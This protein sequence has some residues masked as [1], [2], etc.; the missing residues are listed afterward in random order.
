MTSTF[1]GLAT[2]AAGA[3]RS[4]VP[5]TSRPDDA[6]VQ[7]YLQMPGGQFAEA[8]GPWPATASGVDGTFSLD[9]WMADEVRPASLAWRIY[10]GSA[11]YRGPLQPGSGPYDLG[12]LLASRVWESL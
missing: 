4:G 7:V 6:D 11:G 2:D 3:P 10:I 9:L 1:L 8:Y 5:I 12:D